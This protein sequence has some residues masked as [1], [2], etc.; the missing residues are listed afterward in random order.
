MTVRANFTRKVRD[1][2]GR[3]RR[4]VAN[5]VRSAGYVELSNLTRDRRYVALD[6]ALED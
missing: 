4:A 5:D 1:D 3:Q 2:D 6:G